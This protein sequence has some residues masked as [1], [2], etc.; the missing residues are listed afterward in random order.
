MANQQLQTLIEGIIIETFQQIN[1]AYCHNREGHNL[2]NS[3]SRLVFP[4]YRMNGIRVSE[5]ELR[6]AFVELFCDKIQK[7]GLGLLYSIETPTEHKYYFQKGELLV[8]ND[9]CI[10]GCLDMVIYNAETSKRICIIEFKAK[11]PGEKAYAKDFLKLNSE[12]SEAGSPK[13]K[14]EKDAFGF[15]VQIIKNTN[16]K[17]VDNIRNNSKKIISSR[18]NG[19]I[20]H[21]CYSLQDGKGGKLVINE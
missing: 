12:L 9:K 13:S 14:Y 16:N 19:S 3:F 7:E 17:T 4:Q 10:S 5:Q 15:F 21:L 11:T 20:K 6:F 2:N 1:N 8:D 18:M